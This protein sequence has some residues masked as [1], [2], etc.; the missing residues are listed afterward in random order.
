MEYLNLLPVG[1]QRRQMMRQRRLQWIVVSL[2]SIACGVAVLLSDLQQNSEARQATEALERQFEPI[3]LMQSEIDAIKKKIETLKTQ[4]KLAAELASEKS[5]VTMLGVLSRAAMARPD[6]ISIQSMEF[7]RTRV[8]G[9]D[10]SR[11][12]RSLKL[13]GVAND[14]LDISTF[15]SRLEE[16]NAFHSVHLET[17]SIQE[18]GDLE[19]Q[20]YALQ[21][22]F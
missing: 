16:T 20:G 1:R 15:T 13:V 18:I 10:V 3:Q 21:C 12:D 19:G 8:N 14:S 5:P 4:Q 17:T 22:D 7:T 6:R 11:I 9:D 2:V